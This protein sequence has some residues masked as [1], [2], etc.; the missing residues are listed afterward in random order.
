MML[1]IGVEQPPDHALILSMMFPGLLL[2]ELDASL[3]QRDSDFNPFIPKNEFFRT[4]QEV[5]NDLEASERFVRV[6]DFPAHRFASLSASNR[7]QKSE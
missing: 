7:L 3:A 2:E 5:T 6:F 1:G 4:G